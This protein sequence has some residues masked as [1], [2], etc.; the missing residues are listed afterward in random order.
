MISAEGPSDGKG[1]VF[2]SGMPAVK[3]PRAPWAEAVTLYALC[4]AVCVVSVSI[5]IAT[6][7]GYVALAAS[8]LSGRV[9]RLGSGWLR[10]TWLYAVLAL[11][12]L[13]WLGLLYT[14]DM[15]TGIKLASKTHYWLLLL[16]AAALSLRQ[17]FAQKVS[18]SY[19]LGI[20]VSSLYY[21]LRHA[22]IVEADAGVIHHITYSLLLVFGMM[23]VAF[24][25]RE[26]KKLGAKLSLAVMFAVLFLNLVFLEGRA[27]YLAFVLLSPVMFLQAFGRKHLVKIAV[28]CAVAVALM[29]A[30][31]MVRQRV[32]RGMEDIKEYREGKAETSMGWRFDM[33]KVA[34]TALRDHP[35]LGAG[36]GSFRT[37][38]E[39]LDM[40]SLRDT[41]FKQPHN[42]YLYMASSYGM[43]GLAVL[44]WYFTVAL[45]AGWRKR[46]TAGGFALLSYSLI[47]VVGSLTDTQVIQSHS[48]LLLAVWTG[49][50]AAGVGGG[51][52]AEA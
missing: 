46:S 25:F 36:T 14:E 3:G 8:L 11:I 22:G 12:V 49:L 24:F 41:S 2:S 34:F 19:V 31:P 42:T 15:R 9:F 52:A 30:S 13:P 43:A 51:D 20:S 23:L 44:L 37:Y 38:V 17:G 10:Q 16:P 29:A 45:R 28:V 4:G 5:S 40:P 35:V 47:M 1:T 39:R 21:L 33:W 50:G 27:G 32:V 7:L 6:I 18:F 26:A 48:A